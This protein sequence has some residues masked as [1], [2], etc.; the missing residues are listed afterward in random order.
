[1]RRL[2]LSIRLALGLVLLFGVIQLVPYGRSH[3]N[4][5][6]AAEPAWDSPATRD[7]AV[8][9]CFDCHSNAT[10]W[11]AYASVAPAS[12]LVQSDVDEA[13]EDLNFSEWQRQQR[14]ARHAARE[15]REGDMPPLQYRLMHREARLTDAERANLVRGLQAT[16]G[17]TPEPAN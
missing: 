11:P 14:H 10:R 4:P 6:L 12:W 1:M 5:P 13:R 17:E 16:L 7:L 15:V 9:A 8:R 3:S 2:P